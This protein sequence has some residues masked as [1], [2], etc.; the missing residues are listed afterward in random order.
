MSTGSAP[1]PTPTPRPLTAVLAALDGGARSLDEV[2]RRTG[3][4]STVVR[5]AVEHLVR[6][7]L[8]ETRE[9]AMA[10]PSGGCGTCASGTVEGT[11]GCGADAPAARR[12]GP[13]LVTI[14]RRRSG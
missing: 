4:S 7:G 8:L 3:L 13:A 9:L 11:A 5:A 10:C 14:G 2:A 12:T 6:A 1:T